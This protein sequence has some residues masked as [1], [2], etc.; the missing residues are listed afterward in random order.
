MNFYICYF[1][2]GMLVC[3]I[4]FKMYM[5]KNQIIFFLVMVT[6]GVIELYYKECEFRFFIFIKMQIWL[7]LFCNDIIKCYFLL[8]CISN[9]KRYQICFEDKDQDELKVCLYFFY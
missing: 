5:I 4:E 9:M 3:L 1:K 7:F 6:L 8:K 2:R